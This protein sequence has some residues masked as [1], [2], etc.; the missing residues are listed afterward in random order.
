VI[1]PVF[2]R[3]PALPN[4]Y[5]TYDPITTFNPHALIYFE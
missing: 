1:V 5:S 4:H 3:P 2:D